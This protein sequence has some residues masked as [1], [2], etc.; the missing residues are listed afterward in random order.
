VAV[1]ASLVMVWQV[2]C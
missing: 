2:I 1:G